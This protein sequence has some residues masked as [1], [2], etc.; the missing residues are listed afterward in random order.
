MELRNGTRMHHIIDVRTGRPVESDVLS[1]TV[2]APDVIEAEM[3]A[4][5]CSFWA[6]KQGLSWLEDQPDHAGY[7]IRMD[8]S[9]LISKHLSNYLLESN[10]SE[11]N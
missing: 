1:V 5:M 3:A 10:M 7:I 8:N 4:K 6:V 2:V 11:S 9:K